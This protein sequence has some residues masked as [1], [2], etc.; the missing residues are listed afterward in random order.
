[1]LEEQSRQL[2]RNNVIIKGLQTNPTTA[3]EEVKVFLEQKFGLPKTS[4]TV[5]A[6]GKQ[7][8][9]FNASLDNWES[10]MMIMKNKKS[11]P[12]RYNG[13]HRE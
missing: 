9:I 12:K 1:M 6:V 13:L 8:N 10:K 2:R 7:R 11:C 3:Y 5:H 4:I